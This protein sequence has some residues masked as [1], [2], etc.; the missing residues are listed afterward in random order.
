[1]KKKEIKLIEELIRNKIR[2]SEIR[3]EEFMSWDV[4]CIHDQQLLELS[5]R[6]EKI[7]YDLQ[8]R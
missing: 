7:I 5:K 1:M 8:T 4:E 3:G 2:E 6:N